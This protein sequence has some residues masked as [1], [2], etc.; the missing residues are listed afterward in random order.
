MKTQEIQ[1]MNHIGLDQSKT[2]DLAYKLDKLLADYQMFYMNLRGFHWNIK[3]NKFFELHVKFEELY[4]ETKIRIDEVA[5]RIVT[6]G[7]TPF[8]SFQDYIENSSIDAHTNITTAEEAVGYTLDGFKVLLQKQ[9][10]IL[11][12]SDE[13]NDEGTNALMSDY[14]SEQ[15]KHVWMLS[16]Y[17]S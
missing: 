14:I 12:L 11:D 17:L 1:M 4:N 10:E 15:E 13:L 6:L 2:E 9:R 7:H 3:G 5:E 8:H 16:A